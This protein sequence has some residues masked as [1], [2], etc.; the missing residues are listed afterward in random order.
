MFL[1]LGSNNNVRFYKYTPCS[2]TT[3]TAYFFSSYIT[4]SLT[5]MHFDRRQHALVNFARYFYYR[6]LFY[7]PPHRPL[8]II[9]STTHG[10]LGTKST[11]KLLM[12]NG[13]DSS[14]VVSSVHAKCRTLEFL[15]SKQSK[16]R[17]TKKAW[18]RHYAAYKCSKHFG[19]DFGLNAALAF[20][21][22]IS[23][24]C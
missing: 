24:C 9:S 17:Q 14:S 6:M 12:S 2:S 19:S 1:T 15:N 8:I 3:T 4:R 11:L 21:A 22:L 13:S 16:C 23:A 20:G 10:V 18:Q 5:V 7:L